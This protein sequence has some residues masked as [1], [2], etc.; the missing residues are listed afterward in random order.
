MDL[1]DIWS[2]NRAKKLIT[3]SRL[4][5]L[6]N[7]LPSIRIIRNS[8]NCWVTTLPRRIFRTENSISKV[9]ITMTHKCINW[10]KIRAKHSFLTTTM[11]PWNVNHQFIKDKDKGIKAKWTS[12]ILKKSKIVCFHQW[13]QIIKDKEVIKTIIWHISMLQAMELSTLVVLASRE[14]KKT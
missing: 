1:Q 3:N 8:R 14:Q 13:T 2:K 9:M 10:E 12:I 5:K 6:D 4:L 11:L 7:R